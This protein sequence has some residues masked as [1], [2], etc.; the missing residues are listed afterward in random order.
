MHHPTNVEPGHRASRATHFDFPHSQ[1]EQTE[2]AM[3]TISIRENEANYQLSFSSASQRRLLPT[4]LTRNS[5][6][7]LACGG[8]HSVL[9]SPMFPWRAH[10]GPHNASK[11]TTK[12]ADPLPLLPWHISQVHLCQMGNAG[13]LYKW[14]L[15]SSLHSNLTEIYLVIKR[16][17]NISAIAE[18]LQVWLPLLHY[19]KS[20]LRKIKFK[21]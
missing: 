5:L 18:V 3:I 16:K 20:K 1:A 8:P 4:S 17:T 10:W 9:S 6:P 21:S 7:F 2:E 19:S 12:L 15:K 14:I 13:I 11:P